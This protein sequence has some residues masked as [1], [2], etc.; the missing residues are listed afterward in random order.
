MRLPQGLARLEV[1]ADDHVP[2]PRVGQIGVAVV[3]KPL[4]TLPGTQ[5]LS[6][7]GV[8]LVIGEIAIEPNLDVAEEDAVA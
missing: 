1:A 2:S 8:M 7:T 6:V 4:P 5:S 3:K